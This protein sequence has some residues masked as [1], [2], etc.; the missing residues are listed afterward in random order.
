MSMTW[1]RWYPILLGLLV[2]AGAS[3]LAWRTGGTPQNMEKLYEAAMAISSIAVGFLATAM[4]I[5]L[6]LEHN[7][8][9]RQFKDIGVFGRL[10]DYFMA[11]IRWSLGA[12]L[13]STLLLLMPTVVSACLTMGVWWFVAATAAATYYRVVVI[14]AK[15][16]RSV[17][18]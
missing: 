7:R 12:A 6:S 3:F 5:L 16:L 9:V 15:I 17:T 10:I 18:T 11:G 2:G 13:V 1:E 8:I 14:F 4:A